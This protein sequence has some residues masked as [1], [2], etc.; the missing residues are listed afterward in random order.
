M[1]RLTKRKTLTYRDNT[2]NEIVKE[3]HY[4]VLT[5]DPYDTNTMLPNYQKALRKLADYEDVEEQMKK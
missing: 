4:V 2:T 5:Q 1:E 3:E